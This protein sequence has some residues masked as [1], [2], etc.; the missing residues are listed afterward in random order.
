LVFWDLGKGSDFTIPPNVSAILDTDYCYHVSDEEP[1]IVLGSQGEFK[2]T[3]A[4]ESP[5]IKLFN[6]LA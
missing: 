2:V 3:E 1:L 4:I 6:H 5:T